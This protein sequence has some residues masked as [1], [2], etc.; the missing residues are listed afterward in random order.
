VLVLLYALGNLDCVLYLVYC[1][2]Y[3]VCVCVIY[4][5]IYIYIYIIHV[6]MHYV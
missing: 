3:I 6:Y 5:Y 1:L 2:L 4:V